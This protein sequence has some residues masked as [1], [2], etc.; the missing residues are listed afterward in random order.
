MRGLKQRIT[1]V[2]S[3]LR[4]RPQKTGGVD[5]NLTLSSIQFISKALILHTCD[6]K[7][8]KRQ[9]NQIRQSDWSNLL[10]FLRKRLFS[11]SDYKLVGK[12]CA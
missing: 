9:F 7:H 11:S 4:L 12:L 8:F 10:V 1:G 5:S 3:N 6:L 2:D